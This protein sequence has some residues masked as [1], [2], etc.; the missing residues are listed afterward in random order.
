MAHPVVSIDDLPEQMTPDGYVPVQVAGVT[1]KLSAITLGSETTAL[2]HLADAT[3]AHHGSAITASPGDNLTAT[4]VDGQLD[5]VDTALTAI[6]GRL[7]ALEAGGGDAALGD[8]LIDAADAHDASA[9]SFV[10]SGNIVATDVQGAIVELAADGSAALGNHLGSTTAHP[11]N[12][13]VFTP[14]GTIAAVEVQAAIAELDSETQT[15]LANLSAQIAAIP[16]GARGA[17]AGA[18][19]TALQAGI[20]TAQTDLTGLSVTFNAVAGRRYRTTVSWLALNNTL[21]ADIAA[22]ISDGANTQK[23]Q[24]TVTA[25]ANSN[26][27]MYVV[28]EESGLSGPIT[29]KARARVTDGTVNMNAAPTLPAFITVEDIGPQRW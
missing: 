8:H 1:K 29:R 14:T 20:G 2:D 16:D 27:A 17:I 21:T 23:Q 5:Q 25:S 7:D 10:P 12:T 18:Q 22:Y 15:A 24:R 19:V 4:N 11:A 13:I 3:D 9:I 6:D 26:T 28:L